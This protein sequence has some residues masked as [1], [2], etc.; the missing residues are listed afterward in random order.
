[1]AVVILCSAVLGTAA[2]AA[3]ARPGDER[4]ARTAAAAEPV[5]PPA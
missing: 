4:A 1:M 2:A 3:T 5:T